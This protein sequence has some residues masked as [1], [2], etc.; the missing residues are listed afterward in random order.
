MI[1]PYAVLFI[2][3]LVGLWLLMLYLYQKTFI[4][5]HNGGIRGC[6][7]EAQRHKKMVDEINREIRKLEKVKS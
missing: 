7:K 1:I 2:L 5:W 6:T 3:L 4:E